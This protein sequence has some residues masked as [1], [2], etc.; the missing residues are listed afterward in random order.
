MYRFGF[1]LAQVRH[2]RTSPSVGR[3]PVK[4]IFGTK[5][6]ET[7][8]NGTI[9]ST[10]SPAVAW[11]WIPPRSSSE[12]GDEADH[13]IPVLNKVPLTPEE[14]QNTLIKLGGG[15]VNI[16]KLNQK[17]DTITEFIF[18]TGKSTRHLRKMSDTV[19]K[20]LKARDLRHT[21]GFTGAEGGKD[22]DWIIVD[23]HNCAVHLML[24]ETRVALDLE[25]HWSAK[26]RPQAVYSRDA[27]QYEES[28]EAL[29][30]QYPVPEGYG[31]NK[32]KETRKP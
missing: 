21:P 1:R 9:D 3:G 20:A 18:A 4:K 6:Q 8:L 12:F 2:L 14:I 15:E 5:I 25:A 16:L 17:L 31:D 30:E 7:L 29:L 13:A 19:V 11:N 26:K 28:F 24:Y 27:D 32:D 22:D 23:C 10:T